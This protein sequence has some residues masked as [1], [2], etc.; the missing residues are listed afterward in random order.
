M[1]RARARFVFCHIQNGSEFYPTSY[2][3]DL[4]DSSLT[5]KVEGK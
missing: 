3:M 2:V 1:Y 5:G 4:E